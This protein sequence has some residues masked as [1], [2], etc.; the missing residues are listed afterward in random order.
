[1]G[2][3]YT[4]DLLWPTGELFDYYSYPSNSEIKPK[5]LMPNADEYKWTVY[6]LDEIDSDEYRK[7]VKERV[8]GV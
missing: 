5:N 7:T 8:Y 1:M 2:L 3:G 6:E 4:P